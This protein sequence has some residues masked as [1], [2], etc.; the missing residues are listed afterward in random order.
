MDGWLGQEGTQ[1]SGVT[2]CPRTSDARAFF[3]PFARRPFRGIRSLASLARLLPRPP[4][5]EALSRRVPAPA[6]AAPSRL[7]ATLPAW[8]IPHRRRG[9]WRCMRTRTISKFS[10]GGTLV[11]LRGAGCEVVM[12]TLTAGG[13]GQRRPLPGG[14]RRGPAA[15]GRGE[16][17]AVG[18]GVRVP[19][20]GGPDDHPRRSDPPGGVRGGPA[21]AAGTGADGPAGRLHERPRDHQPAGA[22]RL[23]RRVRAAVRLRGAADRRRPAPL[24][25]R[26]RRPRRAAGGA[27]GA[28][29]GGRRFRAD[30]PEAGTARV[31][32]QPAGLAPPAARGGRIPRQHPPVVG[33]AGGADRRGL[34]RG[35]SASIWATRTRTRI[36]SANCWGRRRRGVP[37]YVHNPKRQRGTPRE[38][39]VRCPLVPTTGK[40]GGLAARPSLTLRVMMGASPVSATARHH[41]P[42]RHAARFADGGVLPGGVGSGEDRRLRR[43]TPA[44]P[45]TGDRTGT[46]TFS[47][48]GA[49]RWGTST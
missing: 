40:H 29:R 13:L 8:P 5:A 44:P 22:G 26:P 39:R 38:P 46:R 25:L 37:A 31:S 45:A 34:R 47:R 1:R 21:G 30:R 9:C 2:G 35:V 27:V 28:G 4:R 20:A 18:G 11:R 24:L 32:R 7:F 23:L 42:D 36:C 41:E 49:G 17:G 43:R 19:G 14:D 3:P 15:G 48:C 6:G 10:A 12:V 33:G 16:R